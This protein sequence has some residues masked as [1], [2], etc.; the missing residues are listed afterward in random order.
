VANYL[1][2]DKNSLIYAYQA[3]GDN[4]LNAYVKYAEDSGFQLVLTDVVASELGDGPAR[5]AVA[6]ETW[7]AQQDLSVTSTYEGAKLAQ[8]EATGFPT[9]YSKDDAGDRSIA[10][11]A[12]A[13]SAN[14][15]TVA[16]FSDDGFF[17]N[18]Q[19]LRP[20][21]LTVKPTLTSADL[22]NA[23]AASQSMSASDFATYRD[24]Y[25]A[26]VN[27]FIN[28][29]N[30]GYSKTLDTFMSDAQLAGTASSS[31]TFKLKLLSAGGTLL[32]L[33]G[34][35]LLFIDAMTTAAKAATDLEAGNN[36]GAA[37]DVASFG[38]RLAGGLAD[39]EAGAQLLGGVGFLLGGPGGAAVGAVAGGLLG[40]VVG[41]TLG[42][43]AVK[44]LWNKITDSPASQGSGASLDPRLTDTSIHIYA[45]PDL[46]ALQSQMYQAGYSTPE[47]NFVVEAV[48]SE[49][50]TL[51]QTNSNATAADAL[52]ALASSVDNTTYNSL[53]SIS[54][55]DQSPSTATAVGTDTS[56]NVIKT[57]D[58]DGKI[59][60][61]STMTRNADGTL[62]VT[63]QNLDNSGNV[64]SSSTAPGF[65][66]SPATGDFATDSSA[67][68]TLQR[69]LNTTIPADAVTSAITNTWLTSISVVNLGGVPLG[70]QPFQT[71]RSGNVVGGLVIASPD[72]RV[73]Y[74]T[75]NDNGVFNNS[76]SSIVSDDWRPGNGNLSAPS[77]NLNDII[78]AA[79]ATGTPIFAALADASTASK[80]WT[81][82]DPL[83]ID[84][85]GNGIATTNWLNNSVYFDTT[86]DPTTL[87]PYLPD[88]KLY[89][90]SWVAPGT[91][92]LALDLNG[93]G[94][95][96]DI[97]ELFS[98]YFQ[99][100]WAQSDDI[101]VGGVGPGATFANGFSALASLTNYSFRLPENAVFSPA[102]SAI[103]PKTGKRYW[104]EV[105]V[106]Q[107]INQN[108][109]ADPGELKT[110]DQLGIASIGLNDT[111][112]GETVNGGTIQS[113]STFT[114]GNGVVGELADVDL[115]A[116]TV[117]D[118]MTEADG[119]EIIQSTL[120]PTYT[121]EITSTPEIGLDEQWVPVPATPTYS[122]VAQNASGHSYTLSSGQLTDNTTGAVVIQSGATGIFSTTQ[123]DTITVAAGDTTPYW[124]GGG[125]GAD[126]L[127]GGAGNTIFLINSQTIVHG[128]T[129]FNIAE[130]D[131]NNPITVDLKTD[132]LQE[133][134]G[135]AGD[136]VFNAS[137][138]TWNVFMQGGA[139]NNIM[140]GGA[141][142]DAFSG[143]TGDDL[144]E[145]GS[146]SSVI[147]AG[148]GNDVIYGGSGA[149][150]A[151]QPVYVNAGA[152]SN[153][154]YV[155]RLYEG[156]LGREA[157]LGGF[158]LYVSDLN[159]GTLSET[160]LAEA[161]VTSAEWQNRYGTQTDAQF[162]TSV[163][164]GLVGRAPV[165]SEL[166]DFTQVLAAGESR[167]AVLQAVAGSVLSQS[168]WGSKHPGASDI[169]YGGPGNDIVVPGTNNTVV[170]AGSGQMTV[171]GNP[172]GF[173]VAGFHGSYADYT[174]SHNA[175]GSVTVT[176]SNNADGDGTV[177]LKNVSDLD[178]K[179]I[180]QV[181]IANALG[182]PVNDELNIGNAGQVTT[183]SSGQ[184]VIAASTLLANDL[185]YAGNT[186]SISVLLDDNDNAIAR[187]AS[188]QVHGGVAALSADG[189][190]IT[191][192]PTP[193]FTGVMSF[194]YHLEDS[195]GQNGLIVNQTGTTNTAELAA[196][197]YLNTPSQPTDPLF[198]NEWFLPAANVLAA[199]QDD[200]TGAGVSVGIFD[201]SGIADFT[202]P[203]L[204]PNAGKEV[205]LDG[206][207][208]VEQ[209]GTHATLVAGVIGAAINGE[210]AVGVAP[211]ATLSSEDVGLAGP[212]GAE[213]LANLGDW[214]NYDVVNNSFELS[215]P[216]N[217]Y[218]DNG[219]LGTVTGFFNGIGQGSGTSFFQ[220]AIDY[221]RSGKGTIVVVAGGNNRSLGW[222]TNDS[223]LTNSPYAIT[224]G[225]IDAVSDLATLQ[226][227]GA[228][229]STPG[230]SILVSAPANDI[231]SDGVSYTNEFGQQFGA[232]VETAQG[233]SFA[234][235]IVSGVVA[236]MLQAN[237]NLSWQD[238]QEILAYSSVKVDPADT[239]PFVS[240]AAAGTGWV[241]NGATN[242]NGGGLHYS[243][244]YGF[245]EVDA[246]AAAQLAKTWQTTNF[247]SRTYDGDTAYP[248]NNLSSGP[249]SET[250]TESSDLAV[251]ELQ[252]GVNISNAIRSDLTITLT[253]PSGV[254]S[255]LTARPGYAMGEAADAQQ[256]RAGEPDDF[257]PA[258][259]NYA[260]E[261]V[262]DWG[263]TF[264]GNW[265]V[266][267]ADASGAASQAVVNGLEL[268]LPQTNETQ[269]QV[270]V[271]T[272]E[273]AEL[274]DTPGS[275]LYDPNNAERSILTGSGYNDT[276]NVAATTGTVNLDLTPGSTD[277]MI[278]GRSLS[279][280]AGTNIDTV[281]LGD[282]PSTVQG[283]NDGDTFY[284]GA[285]V[286]NIIGGSGGTDI[287]SFKYA[288]SGVTVGLP[289]NGV[290]SDTFTNIH[291]ITGSNYGD[292]FSLWGG[293]T[294]DGGGGTNTLDYS[295]APAGVVVNLNNGSGTAQV[296]GLATDTISN[297]THLIGSNYANTFSAWGGM[298]LDGGGGTSTLDY[299]NAPAGV[300]VD[301]YDGTAQVGSLTAD[302]ITNVQDFQTVIGSAYDD[303]FIDNGNLSYVD[304]GFGNNTLDLSAD[305]GVILNLKTGSGNTGSGNTISFTN[306]QN[307][308]GSFNGSNDITC[309]DGTEVINVG[310]DFNSLHAGDGND[311][312]ICGGAFDTF[313]MGTGNATIIYAGSNG[314]PSGTFED[315]FGDAAT[316]WF[317]QSGSDLVV[318]VIGSTETTTIQGW[319]ANS[320]SQLREV[321]AIDGEFIN[322]NH[323]DSLANAMTAYQLANP[324]FD[325]SKATALPNAPS[326]TSGWDQI[327]PGLTFYLLFGSGST[328]AL[329]SGQSAYVS[330]DNNMISAVDSS[331]TWVSLQGTGDTVNSIG[332]NI[333]LD[334][335]ASSSNYFM[336]SSATVSGA[337]NQ[338]KI[339][340][341][342]DTLSVAGSGNT[343]ILFSNNDSV[344]AS[345]PSQTVQ[346]GGTNEV[347][348][349]SS[350][351]V[352]LWDMASANVNGSNNSIRLAY[353]DTITATGTGQTYNFGSGSG[354]SE[355]GA[356]GGANTGEVD[357]GSGITDETVWFQ[358][359]GNNLQIDL[360][361]STDH[362]TI[363]DWFGGG[364]PAA[365]QSF[366][367]AD[368]LR[369]DAQINQLV[370]VMAAFTA[371]QP[372]FNPTTVS[373][374]PNDT[375]LQNTIAAS[376]HS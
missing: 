60:Q 279:I 85:T 71:D 74:P 123:N 9:N 267:I 219:G 259:F 255:I 205:K 13:D 3:G 89:H 307:V 210:G 356:S 147:H 69:A 107:D 81:N 104:S 164:E 225:G 252:I 318:Q 190:T 316:L 235:P 181:S 165:A 253:S 304:G 48:K 352:D 213:I 302:T 277:S 333:D 108:G 268:F 116:S 38:G 274:S 305:A 283:N 246:L 261:T 42:D 178:F 284:A 128:G 4:L 374:V 47:V 346:V 105:V 298:T 245:G 303:D 58:V 117:G 329:T 94:K 111:T 286:V 5:Q 93:D 102:T 132:N 301:F 28:R 258:D 124:L 291:D 317:S 240:G 234:A 121:L 153:A 39:A 199:L 247:V 173:S 86:V 149:A 370:S 110:L 1:Y 106:W 174:L 65:I 78:G 177:T 56:G 67:A 328:I 99:G 154:A 155:E 319:F 129:G 192:T 275:A 193:G 215:P 191:F 212:T 31:P 237:P 376:W 345:G 278:D 162:V 55:D 140:I 272:D 168:Y 98:N 143:G 320:S 339:Y 73:V 195:S 188:G 290:V 90:T 184:Y 241:F 96:D 84:L 131:D 148:S 36:I 243:P 308:I 294:L 77:Q 64:T 355:I 222:N 236:D 145:A 43:A 21:G 310:G 151:A 263:E 256:Y 53:G 347:L 313:F 156:G 296:G 11:L 72:V 203:D 332:N 114:T 227:S 206:S 238:V 88:G 52:S 120:A 141:A 331:G 353:D 244:D 214:A 59:T 159:N 306:I 185:D 338:I 372:G 362:L 295:N 285:G 348:S 264:S 2:F 49:L 32:Q 200:Y 139:G 187:G 25:R 91:G 228:P 281:Y 363:D 194:R 325:P 61:I 109:L 20:Y 289:A 321:R 340:D 265:T 343:T 62:M 344:T 126:T 92:I 230:Y 100:G 17:R 136:G 170:Y 368:G 288:N 137:G 287:V 163:F 24:S 76:P 23:A 262:A 280:A 257:T 189:T 269:G 357:F 373:Q 133:I 146:G 249:F 30:A 207:L 217:L 112:P 354:Q 218:L 12:R 15:D 336:G 369:L 37:E 29:P 337:D 7:I 175:D 335:A 311:T 122:F 138:T 22:L 297:F 186:L 216:F 231:T 334:L 118:I 197:V 360:M 366:A 27:P 57:T 229:F 341:D 179:D 221:G 326:L 10:E 169:I 365:V 248:A 103:D 35:T 183:N 80:L 46:S 312:L 315:N 375:T 196:T 40:G 239:N 180:T 16:I 276:L 158:Q 160:S 45:D 233:T 19:L 115:S 54:V 172:N 63:A 135:G 226:I 349:I 8:Y 371:S 95:I 166:A 127:T 18:P 327:I 68:N 50:A 113:S 211:D 208:G 34:A 223:E 250:F 324:G 232:S 254:T 293:M 97:T 242:W 66:G 220:N 322:T 309:G 142:N 82:I 292:T 266:S 342:D 351:T 75:V 70:S 130:V 6:L 152:A 33:G 271:Y 150:A 83:V 270:Y 364:N 182:M 87:D 201:A 161:F 300:V 202:N 14:G 26:N 167:G 323:I 204:A 209:I 176:N 119:G 260:F 44:G 157:D 350:G 367:T 273:F 171:I 134:I 359:A 144:I 314:T 125:S 51:Q 282:G 251:D 299:S 224:V 101:P 330:G 198:D 41:A 79:I 358:Q 361:G